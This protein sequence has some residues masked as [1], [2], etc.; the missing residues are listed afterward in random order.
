[1]FIKYLYIYNKDRSKDKK[2][3][4]NFIRIYFS[5]HIIHITHN[6]NNFKKNSILYF[7]S[8]YTFLF[9]FFNYSQLL[10]NYIQ[11]NKEYVY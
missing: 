2:K 11:K 4:K 10:A 6:G 3:Y 9:L 5:K 1:M 8:Q 7:L